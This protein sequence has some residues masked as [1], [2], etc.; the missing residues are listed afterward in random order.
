MKSAHARQ[1]STR[2]NKSAI[3]HLYPP[4]RGVRLCTSTLHLSSL[5][6]NRFDGRPLAYFTVGTP[7]F[8]QYCHLKK[9]F[10]SS[11][12]KRSDVPFRRPQSLARQDADIAERQERDTNALGLK[13]SSNIDVPHT[14]ERGELTKTRRHGWLPPLLCSRPQL[15]SATRTTATIVLVGKIL[16]KFT[17]LKRAHQLLLLRLCPPTV[18]RPVFFR[19]F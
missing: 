8:L 12:A 15:C 3:G 14:V 16:R 2:S 11:F 10:N 13:G 7:H 4:R 9:S 18:G 1:G 5:L 19:P 17:C 6:G